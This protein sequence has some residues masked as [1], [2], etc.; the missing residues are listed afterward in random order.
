MPPCRDRRAA[1]APC[2]GLR[3]PAPSILPA[4]PIQANAE[5]LP[6]AGIALIIVSDT[7][8][9]LCH[10]SS[11]DPSSCQRFFDTLPLPRP[12]SGA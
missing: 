11:A 6:V 1:S 5:A 2:R 9:A 4:F 12:Y 8:P 3:Q 7:D 10:P